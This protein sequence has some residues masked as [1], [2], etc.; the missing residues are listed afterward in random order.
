GGA[1]QRHLPQRRTP[2]RGPGGPIG[3]YRCRQGGVR[4]P[5]RRAVV[6]SPLTTFR[7]TQP[8]RNRVWLN[9][10]LPKASTL[11]GETEKTR[12]GVRES[13]SSPSWWKHPSPTAYIQRPSHF[14]AHCPANLCS[15]AS[16]V[17]RLTVP[18]TITSS[19]S[20]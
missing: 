19:P 12:I 16:S 18:S 2:G 17:I 10:P 8:K 9:R 15:A 20:A 5:P 14:F 7:L 6:R 4:H 13:P 3:G 11:D 1:G